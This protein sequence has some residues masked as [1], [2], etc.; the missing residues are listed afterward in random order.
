MAGFS[1]DVTTNAK[2]AVAEVKRLGGS[3]DD[4]AYAL[5][6]VAREA[7]QSGTSTEKALDKIG[8]AARDSAR[9]IDSAGSKVER[10]F[11]DLV[12]DAKKA[13][14][15]VDD[16]GDGGRNI[17]TKISEGTRR[18]E[19]GLNEFRDEASSTAREA[20]A[21]FDGSAQS[22]GDAFQEIAANAFAGF[23][24]AGA[25]AGIAAAAGIGAAVAGFEAV[26]EANK[27]SQERIDEWVQKYIDGQGR[28]QEEAVLTGVQSMFGDPDEMKRVTDIMAASGLEQSQIMRAMAGDLE[29]GRAVTDALAGARGNLTTKMQENQA[30]HKPYM[31]GLQAESQEVL[32]AEDAWKKHTGELDK[33]TSQYSTYA[34]ALSTGLVRMAETEVAAGRASKSV[35]EFGDSVYVLPDGKQV[36]VDAETGKAT[37]DIEE[38]KRI[39]IDTKRTTVVVDVDDSAVRRWVPPVKNGTVQYRNGNTMSWE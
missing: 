4:V 8:D 14:R 18:A 16:V 21:S 7:Q 23:G 29:D 36:M 10:T 2:G 22:V 24:P 6:D 11:R 31:D 38:F 26:D 3:L 19:E 30:A 5:D 28:V 12:Q 1:L 25:V 15:A 20:A 32:K 27:R 33:A 35:D 9:D 37:Q 17:G 13:E 39:D 34:D